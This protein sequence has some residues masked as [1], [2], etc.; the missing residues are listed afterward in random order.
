[1][2][3]KPGLVLLEAWF[4]TY[5]TCKMRLACLLKSLRKVTQGHTEVHV[6]SSL[7]RKRG[8]DLCRLDMSTPLSLSLSLDGA[9][10]PEPVQKVFD[11]VRNNADFMP[12]WQM[13]VCDLLNM[14]MVVNAACATVT[15]CV[16]RGLG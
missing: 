13:E 4:S 11:R 2:C 5:C 9:L 6:C 10:V 8:T 15:A 12:T 1:M 14:V 7:V 16:G 3:L